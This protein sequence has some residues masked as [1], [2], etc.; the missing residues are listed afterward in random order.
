[1]SLLLKAIIGAGI[2][3]GIALISKSKNFFMAGMI[4]LF[5]A[6]GT[7][8][9]FMVGYQRGEQDLQKTIVFSMFS[10]IPYLTYLLGTLFALKF[11][12]SVTS[13]ILIGV[14]SWFVAAGPLIYFWK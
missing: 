10:L 11:G 6:F 14:L 7:L 1:M 3:I 2:A 9:H 5:P 8:A 12:I 4:P 13:S